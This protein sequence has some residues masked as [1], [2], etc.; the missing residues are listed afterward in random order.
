MR[1]LVVEDHKS[2]ARFI[3]SG[4][5]SAGFCVDPCSDGDEG[6]HLVSTQQY[7]VIVLD[8]MLP[9]RD[10]LSILANLRKAKNSVPVI[11][12]TA[13]TTLDERLQGLNLGADDYLTKPFYIEELIARIHAITRRASGAAQSVLQVGD[14]TVNLLTREVRRSDSR[15][16]LTAREFNLLEYLMRSPGRVLTRTQLLEHVWGYYFD[17]GTNLVE[18]NIQRLRKK[19]S[20]AGDGS[21]LIETVRGMGYRISAPEEDKNS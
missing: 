8:I 11:L 1:I 20:E 7:D 3:K 12:L 4:L 21:S 5:E 19:L 6:F 17:P 14:L 10:G 2:I 9:G 15:I 16:E 18:V 13:R